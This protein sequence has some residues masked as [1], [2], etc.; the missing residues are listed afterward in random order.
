MT[1]PFTRFFTISDLLQ[2]MYPSLL[3]FIM[4][5]PKCFAAFTKSD[6]AISEELYHSLPAMTLR[7]PKYCAAIYRKWPFLFQC[8]V[9]QFTASDLTFSKVL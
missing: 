2:V 6:P 9:P 1:S 4:S 3:E 7:F 8:V 5:L